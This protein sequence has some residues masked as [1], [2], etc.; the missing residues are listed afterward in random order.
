[1]WYCGVLF[2]CQSQ[3]RKERTMHNVSMACQIKKERKKCKAG[4]ML[5]KGS[6]KLL[7]ENIPG[8]LIQ[9]LKG[10]TF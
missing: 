7:G 9:E 2:N 4:F 10:G 5:I 8:S 3:N 6:E 1:M